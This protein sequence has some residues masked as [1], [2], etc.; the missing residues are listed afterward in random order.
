[1]DNS[2]KSD[3]YQKGSFA[4]LNFFALNFYQNVILIYKYVYY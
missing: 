1:M 4:M 3:Q 2:V